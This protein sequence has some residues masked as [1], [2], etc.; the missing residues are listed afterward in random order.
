MISVCDRRVGEHFF[1]MTP[2]TARQFSRAWALGKIGAS[3]RDSKGWVWGPDG[4]VQLIST[5]SSYSWKKN[6]CYS[7]SLLDLWITT[8]VSLPVW[9][10][11]KKYHIALISQEE[12]NKLMASWLVLHIHLPSFMLFFFVGI[13]RFVMYAATNYH[14]SL[15]T[16]VKKTKK[17][18]WANLE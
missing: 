12:V 7:G 14:S 16:P 8:A 4:L 1:C 3:E 5:L 13:P 9:V 17:N 11:R 6:T 18:K 2:T 15:F 10:M